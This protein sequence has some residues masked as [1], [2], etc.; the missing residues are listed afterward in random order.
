LKVA[1]GSLRPLHGWEPLR[2]IFSCKSFAS[3]ELRAL[4]RALPL[5]RGESLDSFRETA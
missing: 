1:D 3:E 4:G 2:E 5:A